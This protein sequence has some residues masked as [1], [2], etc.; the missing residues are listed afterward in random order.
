MAETAGTL[1]RVIAIH[2][3]GDISYRLASSGVISPGKESQ[4]CN[5]IFL[6]N[7][8]TNIFRSKESAIAS[9]HL[10]FLALPTRRNSQRLFSFQCKPRQGASWNSTGRENS[11]GSS[12]SKEALLHWSQILG[13]YRMC[14]W[15]QASRSNLPALCEE[16]WRCGTGGY[17]THAWT[18]RW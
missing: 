2:F 13:W 4:M 3:S 1:A 17:T 8:L 14:K 18:C 9:W 5:T 15:G 16:F 10:N 6:G 12:W 7:S 11:A